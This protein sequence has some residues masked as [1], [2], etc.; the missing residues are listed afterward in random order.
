[1]NALLAL[2]VIFLIF[3][4]GDFVAS[5]TKALVSMMLFAA[6]VF[7]V[8]FWTGL[9][10]TIFDDSGLSAFAG[11]TISMFLVHIGTT[12]KVRDF[13]REWKTVV[14]VL[15]STIAIAMGVYFVGKLFIDRYYALVGAPILAG[16]MVAYFVMNGVSETVGRADIS[17]FAVLVLVFQSFIGVPVASYFC[18]KEGLRVRDEYRA[19]KLTVDFSNGEGQHKTLLPPIPEKYNTANVILCKLALVGYASVLLGKAT[20]VS[21]L[22]YA[23]ILGVLLRE[24]GF[25][26][27]AA[28]TK[29]NGFAFVLAGA[30]CSIFSGLVNTT[31]AM[32]A[33]MIVPLLIVMAIGLVCCAV[34]AIVMGKIVHFSCQL[35]IGLAVTAFFGFPGTYLISNEVAR[36]SGDSPE[37]CAAVMASIMPK[38][39]IAGIVSVSVV[40]GLLAG[41]MVNWA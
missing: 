21:M 38:M 22:I 36:A 3:S 6:V 17:V 12:I 27:E 41:I 37:E 9:P 35:S 14:I 24:V 29:C 13:A 30:T 11:V 33:S 40:S 19:G 28:L 7:M 39:I 20:S 18:K 31:P 16:G 8:A 32:V 10:K 4:V 2:F 15:F 25:L 5:K 26:D 1:M 23:L 34:V